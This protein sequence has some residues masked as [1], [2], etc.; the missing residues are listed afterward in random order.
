LL[1]YLEYATSTK[2]KD[3]LGFVTRCYEYGK[4]VGDPLVGFFAEF[5][6]GTDRY[7]AG[8]GGY[9][10]GEEEDFAA[11]KS[12]DPRDN[13]CESC[14]VADMI[15]LAL[16]LTHAGAGDYWEDA[17]R[18]VRNQFAE[19]QLT[20]DRLRTMLDNLYAK[21]LFEER[22][23]EAWESDDIE[24]CVG[25]FSIS[26]LPND[27]GLHL[28]HAC[29]TGNSARTLF[30]IWDSILTRE[31]DRVRVNLLLN[32][33][34]PW[35]DVD[36]YLPYEGKVALKIK[37]AK[38][39]AVRVPEWTDQ[40][41]VTCDVNGVGQEIFWS[42]NYVE[43]KELT[44]GDT[45]TVEFPITEKT[46][47]SVIGDKAFKLTMKGNTVIEI[48]PPGEICPL[49]QREEYKGDQAP[50]KKVTRFASGESILW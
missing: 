1:S 22:P 18:W 20:H 47:F 10:P 17:D 6:R 19:N 43:F 41:R 26:A 49:Y 32:R 12:L 15:G 34:S 5:A 13:T 39:V 11:H 8:W 21:E 24:R 28:G 3:L 44:P 35:L 7:L 45:V 16:K 9:W 4:A 25:G 48:D 50:M 33:S 27:W 38:H 36:S 29:C 23:V 30:W 40:T 37:Q 14:E 42:G 31:D 46:F 2:D